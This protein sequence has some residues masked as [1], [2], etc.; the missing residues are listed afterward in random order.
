MKI[1]FLTLLLLSAIMP[2]YLSGQQQVMD[3]VMADTTLTGTS[4]SVCFADAVTGEMIYCH[5]ADR[6]LASASV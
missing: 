5:D 3:S 2:Q 6:N 1:R 4:W